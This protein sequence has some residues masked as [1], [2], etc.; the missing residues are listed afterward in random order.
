MSPEMPPATHA[1]TIVALSSSVRLSTAADM[2]DE[3]SR[4]TPTG[5]IGVFIGVDGTAYLVVRRGAEAS[6]GRIRVRVASPDLG[7]LVLD[8]TCAMPV[9]S[10]IHA[11]IH[12]SLTG[13][14]GRTCRAHALPSGRDLSEI[15]VDA[16]WIEP[17]DSRAPVISVDPLEYAAARP[18]P[19]LVDLGAVCRHLEHDH[20]DLLARLVIQREG[21]SDGATITVHE[22]TST[23][24]TLGC[25]S[26]DG[27]SSMTWQFDEQL[28]RPSDVATWI[29]RVLSRARQDIV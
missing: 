9:P 17:A 10:E 1:R 8:G 6:T 11:R 15:R 25:L 28:T 22:L 5:S 14:T 29:V 20:G 18:D 12:A 26:D 4:Q 23:R 16:M 3:P 2:R 13:S 21:R 27:V 19:W 24:L 7:S